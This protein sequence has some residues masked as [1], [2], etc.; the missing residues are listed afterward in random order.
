MWWQNHRTAL[1]FICAF[2]PQNQPKSGSSLRS[3]HLSL[4]ENSQ[5]K[6]VAKT[7]TDELR[8]LSNNSKVETVMVSLHGS[9]RTTGGKGRSCQGESS[10]PERGNT[11]GAVAPLTSPPVLAGAPS[12]SILGCSGGCGAARSSCQVIS[13]M[14]VLAATCRVI[15]LILDRLHEVGLS[16]THARRIAALIDGRYCSKSIFVVQLVRADIYDK[17][18][19][20]S[21]QP[22]LGCFSYRKS[23]LFLSLRPEFWHLQ[24]EEI[25]EEQINLHIVRLY[26]ALPFII[27]P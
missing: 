8:V 26:P 23:A 1:T 22:G 10:D 17:S 7:R 6:E 21:L 16:I 12:P 25:W 13:K 19:L 2:T 24:Y 18:Q 14:F 15:T 9:S 11:W 20:N 4:M 27:L 5:D 3:L